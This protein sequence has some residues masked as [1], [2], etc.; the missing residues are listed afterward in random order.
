[1]LNAIQATC[2]RRTQ[3]FDDVG[4]LKTF[5][6]LDLALHGVDHA[7]L[8]TFVLAAGGDFDLFD[9]HEGAVDGVHS[10]EHLTKR[11]TANQSAFDPFD[12]VLACYA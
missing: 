7:F 6:Q 12:L 10:E 11:T 1:M 5:E 2:Q 8:A 3:I 4:M 9:S